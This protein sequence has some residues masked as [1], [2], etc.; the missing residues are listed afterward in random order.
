[1]FHLFIRLIVPAGHICIDVEKT[2]KKKQPR[3]SQTNE[4]NTILYLRK[5]QK[6]L[7]IQIL[8][9]NLVHFEWDNFTKDKH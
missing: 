4:Q 9:L 2:T 3:T 8:Y 6:K 1:M 7:A 5:E